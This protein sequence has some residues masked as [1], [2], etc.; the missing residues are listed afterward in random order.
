MALGSAQAYIDHSTVTATLGSVT[1]DAENTELIDARLH[2][3]TATQG[4]GV[5]LTLAFNSL[6]WKP[7]NALFNA[8]DALIGDPLLAHTE[9]VNGQSTQV[10]GFIG[11]PADTQAYI[12][13]SSV[14]A[15]GD[16]SVT[17]NGNQQLNSTVSNTA[18][19]TASGIYGQS[20]SSFNGILASNKVN[21]SAYAYIDEGSYTYST[22]SGTRTLADGDTVYVANGFAGTGTVG[23]VYRHIGSGSVDL[24]N[25][26]FNDGT[27][28]LVGAVIVR[29]QQARLSPVARCR[30]RVRTT[31][32]SSPISR[33]CRARRRPAMAAPRS[34]RV[35]SPMRSRP[36]TRRRR[37]PTRPPK[38]AI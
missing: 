26:K 36:I 9:T 13:Q 35:R 32:A 6:G 23:N 27:W 24:A 7:Q 8:I 14:T 18:T 2:A 3:A 5:G 29:H 19:S 16:L 21:G 11:Q 15:G 22:R 30:S 31:R 17:A 4:T 1:V 34:S 37:I 25:A 33:S 12:H 28:A 10:V 38:Y 20:G